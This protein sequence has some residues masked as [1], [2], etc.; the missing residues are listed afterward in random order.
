M[1]TRARTQEKKR[2]ARRRKLFIF[3]V[4]SPRASHRKSLR[5]WG[6][7]DGDF[8]QSADRFLRGATLRV[9]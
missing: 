7:W 1:R 2:G 9:F 3:H 8:S 4:R 5:M 6:L